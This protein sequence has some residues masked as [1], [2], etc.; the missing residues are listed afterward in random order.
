LSAGAALPA[1]GA[2]G[3]GGGLFLANRFEKLGLKDGIFRILLDII[4]PET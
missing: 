4:Y 3:G 2:A 1:E